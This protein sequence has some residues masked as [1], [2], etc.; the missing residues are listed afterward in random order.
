MAHARRA[1]AARRAALDPRAPAERHELLQRLG[2]ADMPLLYDKALE[3]ALFRTYAVPS[4]SA[5]LAR[6]GGFERD[7]AVRYDDTHLLLREMAE[8][9]GRGSERYAAASSRLNSIHAA[10]APHATGE[11]FA[12]VLSLFVLEPIRWA[13]R[14]GWRPMSRSEQLANLYFWLEVGEDMGIDERLLPDSLEEMER[15]NEGFE[16]ERMR[17]AKSNVSTGEA[18]MELLL[19]AYPRMLRPAVRACV[20]ALLDDRLLLAMGYE[21][22]PVWLRRVVDGAMRARALL[23]RLLAPPRLGPVLRRT[24]EDGAPRAPCGALLPSF[25]VYRTKQGRYPYGAGYKIEELGDAR[26]LS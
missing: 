14:Y 13:R 15:F 24:P 18:T 20:V 21:R 1:A 9:G 8:N 26:P 17:F 23:L 5:T 22:P 3:F 2:G 7:A 10:R 11:E 12:Y 6:S 16:A 4:I 19:S 25:N